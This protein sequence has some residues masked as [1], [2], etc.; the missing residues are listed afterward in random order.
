MEA[1]ELSNS[2]LLEISRSSVVKWQGKLQTKY[3]WFK[4][5]NCKN[6]IFEVRSGQVTVSDLTDKSFLNPSHVSLC[7]AY[8]AHIVT[9]AQHS[10]RL[11]SESATRV[12][13]NFF[14]K[15]G[16]LTKTE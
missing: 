10:L 6:I 15:R 1:E 3:G 16:A 9:I 11:S 13:G 5:D 12:P 14:S 8:D 7:T 2:V 4:A